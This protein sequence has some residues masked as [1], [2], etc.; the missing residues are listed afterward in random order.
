MPGS[1]F[2]AVIVACL[3]KNDTLSQHRRQYF[4]H[5]TFL[6][7]I[8]PTRCFCLYCVLLWCWLLAVLSRKHSHIVSMLVRS[9]FLQVLLSAILDNVTSSLFVSLW[10]AVCHIFVSRFILAWRHAVFWLRK[11]QRDRLVAFKVAVLTDKISATHQPT[12]L[13]DALLPYQPAS[14][15]HSSNQQILQIWY[16]NTK[17][18]P[19]SFSTVHPRCG[20]RF[21]PLSK[22]SAG[23]SMSVRLST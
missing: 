4:F 11:N 18:G 15:L 12:Y 13:Y 3:R 9:W 17:F 23:H 22:Q 20:I 1:L 6:N 19:R 5:V 16:M 14:A 10:Q 2:W 7:I 21:L 8:F